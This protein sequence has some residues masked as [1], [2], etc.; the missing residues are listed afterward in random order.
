MECREDHVVVEIRTDPHPEAP[1]HVAVAGTPSRHVAAPGVEAPAAEDP[2]TSAGGSTQL[3]RRAL[4]PGDNRP[5]NR[6]GSV[7]R[8]PDF[9][10]EDGSDG[11][12]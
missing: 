7:S 6:S 1:S 10:M 8:R 2:S 12:Y 3:H 5:S 9:D 11:W 4:A